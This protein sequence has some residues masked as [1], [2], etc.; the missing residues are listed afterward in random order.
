MFLLFFL[1]PNGS[2]SCGLCCVQSSKFGNSLSRW[3]GTRF[4]P[5]KKPQFSMNMLMQ[6]KMWC[7]K[8][9]VL[10][11]EPIYFYL[12]IIFTIYI[13]IYIHIH[14]HINYVCIYIHLKVSYETGTVSRS[15]SF[16]FPQLCLCSVNFTCNPQVCF[17]LS[18]CDTYIAPDQFR[19]WSAA[20]QPRLEP[21]LQESPN[22]LPPKALKVFEGENDSS[23]R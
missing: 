16:L 21:A 12:H 15:R 5:V 20:C 13:Y 3:V 19:H 22:A 17:G 1:W 11:I 8:K 23:K 14:K 7:R 6:R 18:R 2:R 10:P 9:P 4:C